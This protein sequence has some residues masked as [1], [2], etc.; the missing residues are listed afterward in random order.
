MNQIMLPDPR[1]ASSIA[2]DTLYE[3]VRGQRV[4]LVMGI[5]SLWVASRLNVR[6]GSF[7]DTQL[8]GRVV[9]EGLFILDAVEDLRRRPD[10]AYVS[11]EQWPLDRP[12]PEIGDWMLV[13]DLTVEV[14]SPTDTLQ[15]VLE[16]LEEYFDYGVKQVWLVVPSV[17]KLYVYDSPASVRILTDADTLGNTVV[18]GF[19]LKVGEL[20]QE[21]QASK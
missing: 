20:F 1:T 15:T 21:A 10:V 16:K 7:V 4:E 17:R 6:L 12:L 9:I 2:E 19:S 8:L 3:V 13:P 18:P 11:A 5:Y 14:I